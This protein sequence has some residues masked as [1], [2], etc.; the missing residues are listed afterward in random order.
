MVGTGICTSVV[1]YGWYWY[2]YKCGIVWLA[3]V[4]VQVWYRVVGTGICISWYRVVG[5]GIR[6]SV[7]SCSWYWYMYKCGIV[8]LVLVYV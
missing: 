2:M 7:V 8:W 4:Y 1:S 5:T 3:L 6:I